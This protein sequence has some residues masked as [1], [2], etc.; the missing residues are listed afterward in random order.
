MPAEPEQLL[1]AGHCHVQEP[2]LLVLFLAGLGLPVGH[3]PL[4]DASQEHHGELTPLALV[5][6]HQLDRVRRRFRRLLS[7]LQLLAERREVH[8]NPP[9]GCFALEGIHL[10]ADPDEDRDLGWPDAKREQ[11]ADFLEHPDG[12][13]L[14]ARGRNPAER[15]MGLRTARRQRVAGR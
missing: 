4:L 11:R 2:K 8:G 3:Q 13:R 12:L 7:L 6:G 14:G 10:S 1:G 15:R 9:A 5:H